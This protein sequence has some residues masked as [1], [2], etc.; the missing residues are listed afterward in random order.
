ML[1]IESKTVV[2]KITK[3][4]SLPCS[5]L[6]TMFKRI[7]SLFIIR[8]RVRHILISSPLPE[9]SMK[10]E[11]SEAWNSKIVIVL[12]LVL[13]V[14]SYGPL[15][16][17]FHCVC[18]WA[19]RS[20]FTSSVSKNGEVFALETFCMKGTS[21]HIKNVWIKQLCNRKARD[22]ALVQKSSLGFRETCPRG[23]VLK[24]IQ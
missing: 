23:A 12:N 10:S 6:L 11:S 22:F 16:A 24:I 3:T 2:Y 18:L 13:V 14:Q 15:R 21:V 17:D 9:T 19:L 1:L 8:G 7:I 5:F 4:A 20:G